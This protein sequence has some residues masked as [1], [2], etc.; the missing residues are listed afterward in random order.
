MFGAQRYIRVLPYKELYLI[1][2]GV[3]SQ[4]NWAARPEYLVNSNCVNKERNAGCRLQR[5]SMVVTKYVIPC[6]MALIFPGFDNSNKV[7]PIL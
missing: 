5:G 6:F 2:S 1:F 7:V 4:T 3:P